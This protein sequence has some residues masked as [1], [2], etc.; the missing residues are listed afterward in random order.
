MIV[1]APASR[2]KAE[3]D[4]PLRP[5]RRFVLYW[6]IAN[7]RAGWNFALQQAAARAA[8]LGKP[9]VVL[10]ALRCDYRWASDRLHRFVMDGMA[11]NAQAFAARPVL[12]CRYVE[13]R[14]GAGRGLLEALSRQACLVV[15][16]DFPAFFLPRMVHALARRLDVRLESVDANGLYPM[17]ATERVF[18]SAYSFRRHLQKALPEHLSEWPA[19]DPLAGLDLPRLERLPTEIVAGW[20][21]HGGG[22]GELPIDHAVRPVPA[23]GGTRCARQRLQDFIATALARYADGRNQ[24]DRDASSGL[25]AFLHFGHISAHEIFEAVGSAQEWGPAK[26]RQTAHGRRE[27]WWGMSPGAEAFLDQLVTWRELG[28]NFAA[29]G[30]DMDRYRS[31]PQWCQKTLDAHRSD[32]REHS[33]SLEEFEGAL[34]HDPLWNAAQRQLLREGRIHN[35]LRML[36]GKKILEWSAT[37]ELA[38]DIMIELNNKYA[39]DGRN[40]NSYSGIFWVLGRYDRPWG[41]ERPVFGTIRYMSSANTAKKLRI[42]DY[43]RRHGAQSLL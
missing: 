9:L 38:A 22:L 23:S 10:E 40:P 36:W 8:E 2:L 39:V 5:Q 6:M 16:D 43:L 24:P 41:P 7:R 14:V 11:D 3:N 31:L 21:D 35:Y 20:P 13:P 4:A 1:P 42:K 25:S 34:T 32:S 37:P 12:Y 27:G 19:A 15:T 28:Y 26:L 17:R 33:Y 18:T 29:L 30:T